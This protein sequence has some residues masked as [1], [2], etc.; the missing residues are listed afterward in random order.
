MPTSL[1]SSGAHRF[2]QSKKKNQISPKNKPSDKSQMQ[3]LREDFENCE[4]KSIKVG[5]FK[6]FDQFKLIG[7]EMKLDPVQ[8]KGAFRNKVSL[9]IKKNPHLARKQNS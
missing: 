6:E 8:N 3:K 2:N 5:E 9:N 7:E 1:S 4:F